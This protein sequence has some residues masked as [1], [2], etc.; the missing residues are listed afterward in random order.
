M[1]RDFHDL[2][3]PRLRLAP[4]RPS[5][6]GALHELWMHPEVRRYLWDDQILPPEQTAEIVGQSEEYFRERGFGLWS[7]RLRDREELAGFGGFWYFRDPPELELILGTAPG[8][9][10]SGV[11]TEA[12]A[13]LIRYAFEQLGFSEVRGSA[14]APNRASLRVMEKLGMTPERRSTI[15]GLDTFFYCIRRG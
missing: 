9:Q 2:A 12:G 8:L 7:V 5:E 3:T 13:A 6:A 4:F 14:D 1:S 11:A 10:G 15:K